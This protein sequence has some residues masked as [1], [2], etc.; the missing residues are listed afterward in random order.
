MDAQEDMDDLGD[1]MEP[2]RIASIKAQLQSLPLEDKAR[3][4]NE[5]G[6]SEDFPTA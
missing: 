6:Y 2:D 3:L 5:M 4:A 1:P